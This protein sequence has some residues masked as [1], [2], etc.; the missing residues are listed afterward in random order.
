MK[1]AVVPGWLPGLI[2][3]LAGEN[4]L[5]GAPAYRNLD[6]DV[7]YA[8]DAE[9]ASCHKREAATYPGTAMG[10]SFALPSTLREEVP[11]AGVSFLHEKSGAK[12]RVAFER[13]DLVHAEHRLDEEGREAFTDSRPIAFV[14]GSGDR[15]QTFL[16]HVGSRL[17]QSPIAFRPHRDGWGMAA[18]F[19]TESHYHF[20]RPVTGPCLFCHANRARYVEGTLN[21]YGDPPFEG[22]AI[23][24][25]R[26][27]GAGGLHVA[28]RRTAP[29][30]GTGLDTSIVNPGRLPPDLRDSVCFQCH[31]QGSSRVVKAEHSL[32]EYRPG[33]PLS[34]FFAVFHARGRSASGHEGGIEV[35]SHVERLRES[36]CWQRSD[37]QISCLTCHDPHHTPR[38][39]E[40]ARQ[41]S[42]A[43]LGCHRIE[44][45]GLKHLPADPAH[46]ST[47]PSHCV[48]CHMAK[49]P[50]T[51]APHT[52]FTD[53]LIARRPS[54][55]G[56]ATHAPGG[57][58]ATLVNF[59]EGDAGKPRDLGAAYLV[60]ARSSGD[61]RYAFTGASILASVLPGLRDDFNALRLL[62][63]HYL[64]IEDLPRATPVLERLVRLSPRMAEIRVELSRVYRRSGRPSEALALLE[65]AVEEDPLFAP[66]RASLGGLLLEAGREAEAEAQFLAAVRIDPARAEAHARLGDIRARQ[67]D[68]ARAEESLRTAIVLNPRMVSARM[69]LAR[70]LVARGKRDEAIGQLES[71]LSL[72]PGQEGARQLLD[73]IRGG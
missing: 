17:F 54:P 45:C 18:G 3:V 10:R 39:E 51:D 61:Q 32:Y 2:L 29:P 73:R 38:G 34:D 19:D 9:C 60:F 27:H 36:R 62:A 4:T 30:A 6:P 67:G 5:A 59:L 13:G 23:G 71:V 53:H 56:T 15:G 46:A 65:E 22:L 37:G 7:P 48:T 8:G 24:C 42:A 12:Y 43:C 69:S 25:E 11:E 57:E 70:V 26:C 55:A 20:S 63:E 66:A 33:L 31:L 40:A 14:L 72:E 68:Q 28:E 21:E 1:R 64:V 52:L 35:V 16:I 58:P 47:D 41:F 44:D 50:P 49:R